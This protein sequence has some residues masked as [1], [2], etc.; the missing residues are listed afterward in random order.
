MATPF[1]EIFERIKNEEIRD[2]AT[3]SATE[4]KYKGRVNQLY[5]FDIPVKYDYPFLSKEM[6]A[7]SLTASYSTGTIAIAL[8]TPTVV[9]GTDTVWT[10]AHTG[11]KIKI[12]GNDEIYTFTRTGATAGTISPAFTG[13]TALTASTYTIFQDKYSLDADFMRINKP[14]GIYY[15]D[16]G[17][18][19]DVDLDTEEEFFSR[20]T[21]TPNSR[22]SSIYIPED[23]VDSSGYRVMRINAPVSASMV[24]HGKY[25]YIP[26]ELT[27]YT[28][29]T[30][31]TLANAGTAVTLNAGDAK[32]YSEVNS[33]KTYYFRVDGDGTG[34]ASVWYKI[35]SFATATTFT[36][37]TAYAGTAIS[38]G[39][40]AYTI[41]MLPDWPEFALPILIYGGCMLSSI[42]QDNITQTQSYATLFKV[43]TENISAMYVRNRKDQRI[44]SM[45]E[46]RARYA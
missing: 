29:S 6:T 19:C 25:V 18:I 36:L 35:A 23:E 30:V 1:S 38:R 46:G 13:T 28:G 22:L 26:E 14:T 39:T 31:K 10:T 33:A 3:D 17:Q 4:N 43:T 16:N 15:Y 5:R 11:Q 32:T 8:A 34:S 9:A 42:E 44:K 40:S 45:Y 27:E 41:S 24:L 20:R 7:I 2:G 21:W 37:S 12:D